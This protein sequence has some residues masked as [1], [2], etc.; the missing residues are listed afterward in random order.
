MSKPYG[1]FIRTWEAF[2]KRAN[3]KKELYKFL[4]KREATAQAAFDKEDSTKMIFYPE[5]KGIIVFKDD[6][7]KHFDTAEEAVK[8]AQEISDYINK[9]LK[10]PKTDWSQPTQN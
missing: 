10:D 2:K 3:D 6:T 9:K 8:V 1:P 5:I 7:F 4:S